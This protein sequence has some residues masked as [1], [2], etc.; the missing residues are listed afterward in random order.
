MDDKV[1]AGVASVVTLFIV[2]AVFGRV[3]GTDKGGEPLVGDRVMSGLIAL[4]L[5]SIVVHYMVPNAPM[6][7]V[8]VA[9]T[10][11]LAYLLLLAG[12]GGNVSSS[13]WKVI[14]ETKFVPS[15]LISV[16]GLYLVAATIV[17]ANSLTR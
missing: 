14:S 10:P 1:L 8:I 17:L 11:L 3:A 5:V 15:L 13:R 7:W 12:T 2:G 4:P 16:I 6:G 9:P